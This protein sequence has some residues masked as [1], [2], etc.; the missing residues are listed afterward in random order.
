M[1]D[2]INKID[3]YLDG[4]NSYYQQNEIKRLITYLNKRGNDIGIRGYLYNVLTKIKD[5]SELTFYEKLIEDMHCIDIYENIPPRD[6]IIE[7]R[8]NSKLINIYL[9]YCGD[10]TFDTEFEEFEIEL[11]RNNREECDSIFINFSEYRN[12]IRNNNIV[13]LY[14]INDVKNIFVELFNRKKFIEWREFDYLSYD[15]F[16]DFMAKLLSILIS[17][18]KIIFN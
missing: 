9:K 1:D 5:K 3:K 2:L 16:C 10:Y 12:K 6:I 18:E 7:R 13:D 14:E 15:I 11:N 4:K 8:I 17:S